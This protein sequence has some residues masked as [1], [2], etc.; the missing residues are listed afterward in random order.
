MKE[1]K[2]MIPINMRKV[3]FNFISDSFIFEKINDFNNNS[4]NFFCCLDDK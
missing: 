1:N 4:F 2:A 3:Y